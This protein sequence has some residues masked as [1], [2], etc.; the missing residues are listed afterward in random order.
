MKIR[1]ELYVLTY[2][3]GP[4]S[5]LKSKTKRK[6]ILINSIFFIL[7]YDIQKFFSKYLTVTFIEMMVNDQN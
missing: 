1:K 7:L 3:N 5:D 2:K 6:K 4:N